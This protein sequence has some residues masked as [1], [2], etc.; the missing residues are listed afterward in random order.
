MPRPAFMLVVASTQHGHT[1][2]HGSPT[3][4][5]THVQNRLGVLPPSRT[6]HGVTIRGE[7]FFESS[8]TKAELDANNY[9]DK[10]VFV[11]T[12]TTG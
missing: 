9:V 10:A 3:T 7:H 1:D 6:Q 8:P 5:P 2:T 12:G 4:R 11:H